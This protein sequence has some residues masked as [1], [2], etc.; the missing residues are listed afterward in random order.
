MH[1]RYPIALELSYS[2]LDLHRQGETGTGLTELGDMTIDWGSRTAI[3]DGRTIEFTGREVDVLRVLVENIGRPV[4][5]TTLLAR[6]W[7]GADRSENAVEAQVSALRRKFDDA[8]APNVI[9]TVFGTGYMFTPVPRRRGD[10]DA[11]RRQ[12]AERERALRE[13][14]EAVARRTR[15]LRR[16]EQELGRRVDGSQLSSVARDRGTRDG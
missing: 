5:K 3:R 12:L 7:D 6:V 8:G 1:N 10:D 11:A 13:R 4:A 15:L 9:Q 16:M 14:E 2:V